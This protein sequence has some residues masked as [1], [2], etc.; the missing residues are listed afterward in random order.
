MGPCSPVLPSIPAGP[1]SPVGPVDPT[2]IGTLLSI[3]STVCVIILA[4]LLATELAFCNAIVSANNSASCCEI[5]DVAVAVAVD[6][7]TI[8]GTVPVLAKPV[9]PAV[10]L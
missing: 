6:E 9:A 10:A 1:C 7:T 2:P 3:K 4:S 8:D 5:S